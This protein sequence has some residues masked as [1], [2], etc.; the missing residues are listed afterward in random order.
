MM[1][2]QAI[3]SPEDHRTPDACGGAKAPAA[4]DAQVPRGT[5]GAAKVGE[6]R[7]LTA[8]RIVPLAVIL[9]GFVGFF[10]FDL[11]AYLSFDMLK[12][13]REWLLVQ[14]AEHRPAMV[15]A[16]IALYAAVV[17]FSLPV[18]AIVSISGGFLFGL[19]FGT[20]W[21]VAAATL[22]A[23]LLFL[24]ART[25]FADLLHSKAG[26]WFHKVEA[27]F[28][29]NAFS[30]LLFLRLVPL[31]PFFAVNLVPAFLGVRLR[32]FVLATFIGIVP[33]GFVYTSVGAGLGSVFDS[34]EKFSVSGILTPEI[35]TAMV[36]LA[37][38][39]LVPVAY[40]AWRVRRR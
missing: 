12:Q 21:N 26:P 40:R 13:H 32:T 14:V 31:F 36:G 6:V 7:L 4:A 19:W 35:A 23:T 39:S 17:A 28:Q 11:D 9:S 15:L 16:F 8:R 33:G 24:A 20:L 5:D 22:G 25:V 2:V 29:E 3:I 34:G 10:V 37:L 38:L 1:E 30:Y 27:G 18:A